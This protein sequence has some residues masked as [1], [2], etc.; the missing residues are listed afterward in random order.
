MK[1]KLLVLANEFPYGSWEPYMET[2]EPFYNDVF[3]KVWIAS[4]QLRSEHARTKRNLKGKSVVIPV[5]YKKRIFYLL[6]AMTVLVDSNLYRELLFLIKEKR[7]SMSR[8]VDLF[9]YLSRAHHE[10]RIVDKALRNECKNGIVIYSYRFEYQPY[11]AML[12]KEKWG[13]NNKIISRAHRYDIYEEQH[14]N[15]Y[16]PLRYQVLNGIDCVY[17]CS[18]HGSNYINKRYH[19]FNAKIETKYLGTKDR[20]IR[21]YKFNAN[22][23]Y[24]VVSCST[25][26]KVK[27]VDLI[28]DALASIDDFKIKWTHY[29]DGELMPEIEKYAKDK[30]GPKEN[31]TYNFIGNVSNDILM[32]E[33]K[34]SN[35]F[36]FINVSSSEGIPV[37]IMEAMSFGIPCIA[38]DV[39]GTSE[40]MGKSEY[41][42]DSNCSYKQVSNSIRKMASLSKS[43][44]VD[45]CLNARL[46]WNSMFNADTNYMDFVKSLLEKDDSFEK[47][48]NC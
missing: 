29:G 34:R 35:Y 5:A 18:E 8:L 45:L 41:L 44:Y 23:V 19:S 30:L 39:G 3:D 42:L 21:N 16:I 13:T 48:T 15:D 14:K 4:L 31:I 43:D 17:P 37:S 47:D 11:V 24:E 27:R 46:K 26:T 6:N 36:A 25:L 32:E 22:D 2:E 9:V 7:F 10:A 12:L 28:I 1:R 33:Y 38:T 20:G 40:I